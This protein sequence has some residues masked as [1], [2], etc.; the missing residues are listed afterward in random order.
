MASNVELRGQGANSTF[1][2]FTG[3]A[4]CGYTAGICLAPSTI[5]SPGDEK[6]VC[7][8]TA[9]YSQGTTVI[10]LANCGTTSPGKGALSSLAVGSILILDQVDE[11]ADTGQI[12]NCAVMNVCGNTSPG[13]G[14]RTNGP[15]VGGVSNRSAQQ[16][17]TVTA[18]N[19]SQVT[20]SPGIYMPN[21]RASQK[22]QAWFGGSPLKNT[23]IRN[24]SI[25]GTNVGSNYNIVLAS[26]SG[27]WV[28][29]I[30]SM[31]ANRS[32]ITIDVAAH[33][34]V[35][36]NYFYQSNSHASVSYT[37]ETFFGGSD[38]LVANNI[39]QQV[40]DSMPNC[41]GGCEGNVF[42]YNF[43]VDDVWTQSQGWMQPPFYQH[44][45]G[46]SYNLWE[47]NI[48]PGY[49]ADQVHGT[50][51][52]ET[53]FRNYLTGNQTAGC[54]SAGLN[55]CS[56]QTIPVHLYAGSRY[57]NVVGNVLGQAGYHTNYTCIGTASPNPDPSNGDVSIYA[58]GASGNECKQYSSLSS[59]CQGP[60]CSSRSD[61]DPQVAAYLMRWG[62]YDTVNNGVRFVGS[63]VPSGVSPYGNPVPAS[64]TLPTS[65]YLSNKPSWWGSVAW[66]PIGPD[67]TGGNISGVGG[68]ANQTPAMSC[69]LNVMGGPAA[70]TGGVLGFNAATCYGSASAAPAPPT[71]LSASPQ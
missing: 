70:G 24:L 54:G 48:G 1:L 62:N 9:G 15:S 69:Y 50:H 57:F 40:T 34:E 20:I 51:H 53:L 44:A 32:H 5:P 26:C 35:S 65:F 13:G 31:F 6:N 71:N 22:P 39:S 17:V 14:Q 7:D 37:V 60:S 47:G 4:G 28:N 64:Q 66:P 38:N 19:G 18:I 63:E 21:W 23:G 42:A 52:F 56:Q 3:S 36:S 11:A 55:T 12:W 27:C 41:N 59:Y 8:W 61:A 58:L 67:V 33:N 49:S 68:H 46:D 16:A 2:V 43:A 45:S 10:T 30:R 29:G 25:D